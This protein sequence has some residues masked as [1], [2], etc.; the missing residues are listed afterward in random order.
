MAIIAILA[1]A[2]GVPSRHS[3]DVPD[4]YETTTSVI[5]APREGD[6]LS[7]RFTRCDGP[8]RVNCVVDGDTFWFGRDKI[9]IADI[10]APEIFSPRAGARSRSANSPATGCWPC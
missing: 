9:R 5:P 1:V 2:I 8:I 10:N 3:P 6:M 7:A 4:R